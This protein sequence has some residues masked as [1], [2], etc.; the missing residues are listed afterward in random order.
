MAF[1]H[2]AQR[3]DAYT[4]SRNVF[5]RNSGELVF[6]AAYTRNL[7]RNFDQECLEYIRRTYKQGQNILSDYL[8][9]YQ[10]EKHA[11]SRRERHTYNQLGEELEIITQKIPLIRTT[12]PAQATQVLLFE[13]R[14]EG[15]SV[16]L[17]DSKDDEQE[18]QNAAI[19]MNQL[20]LKKKSARGLIDRKDSDF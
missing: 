8:A 15:S 9:K 10:R 2:L 17:L 6:S 19:Q 7:Q 4:S 3:Q 11:V 5:T 12:A 20:D 1:L 14:G 16:D 18:S 13:S